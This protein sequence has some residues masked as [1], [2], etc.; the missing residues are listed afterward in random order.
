MMPLHEKKLP[1]LAL[2]AFLLALVFALSLSKDFYASTMVSAYLSL[3][4]FSAAI[5]LQMLRRSWL[6][7]LLVLAG[8]IVLAMLD[9]HLMGF[10]PMVMA[11]FSF[12]GLAAFAVLGTH[13]IWAKGE[14]R[15]LLLCGFVPV[16]LFVGS[17]WMASTLL[18]ITARLHPKTLDLFLYSFDSSLRAPISFWTGQVFWKWPWLREVSLLFYIALPLPLALTYAAQLRHAR[19]NALVVMLAFL[20]TGPIGVIFYN[21]LPACG[22]VHIFGAAFPWQPLSTIDAMRMN[23]IPTLIPGARNAIPSL[24]MTWVLLVWCNSRGLPRWIRGIALAFVWFTVLATLGT[25]EHYFIDLVVAFP[26]SLMVQALCS[27]R[28]PFRSG[29]RR[30]A[31]LFGI[32][33]TLLWLA[34]LSFATRLFWI[35]PA[36]PWTMCAVTIS[37]SVLLWHRLLEARLPEAA[38]VNPPVTADH[39]LAA[40]A[41][42]GS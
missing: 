13:T 25:G 22:P 19:S 17:E 10:K 1:R 15:K 41:G 33:V 21:V 40:A 42:T 20:A 29:E 31:F 5:V 37:A 38:E 28:L 16:V 23:V 9:Y 39:P 4:L 18:D 36:I 32:F 11:I 35:S 14:V 34:L 7:L 8:A 3:A 12:L 2:N 6:D 24:H 30:A 27:Y 26:F